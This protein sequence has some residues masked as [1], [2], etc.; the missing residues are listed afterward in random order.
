MLEIKRASLG[1]Q[2]E[3][4]TI[5][6]L[7]LLAGQFV[8]LIGANGTGKSTLLNALATGSFKHGEVQLSNRN[9]MQ[10]EAS[11]R[12]RNIALIDNKFSGY[13]HLSTKEYLD[14]GRFPYT[15]FSGKLGVEDE[16][17]VS[18]YVE[19]LCLEHL[20]EQS[21]S[22]LSDGERQRAGIARAFIQETPL[23]LMDEPTSFLDYPTKLSIMKTVQLLATKEGKLVIM[24]SH[25]LDLCL[26]YCSDLLV[27]DPRAK[28]LNQ[29]PAQISLEELLL[30]AF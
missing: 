29:F 14:L 30:K 4:F 26:K 16:E 7:T 12:S 8:A 2:K 25:D 15:G 3:L 6:S 27:I 18:K 17:I 5:D 9:L 24:A 21:T 1:Y 19:L 10:L 23:L 28:V 20:L 13:D 22:T 11:E